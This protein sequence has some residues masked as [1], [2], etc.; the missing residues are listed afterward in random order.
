MVNFG[1]PPQPPAA[2]SAPPTLDA[3]QQLNL[4]IGRIPELPGDHASAVPH[5]ILVGTALPK[6]NVPA[7][8]VDRLTTHTAESWTQRVVAL[9]VRRRWR[10]ERQRQ[11]APTV[12]QPPSP[13]IG[14]LAASC[15]CSRQAIG[16]NWMSAQ[17]D[18]I[19]SRGVGGMKGRARARDSTA[20]GNTRGNALVRR[21][22][23]RRFLSA[24]S[25]CQPDMYGPPPVK[26]L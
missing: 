13:S 11:A 19:A 18:S 1:I 16:P 12:P 2:L 10:A 4:A 5:R 21:R 14:H 7:P 20:R 9:A 3:P 26:A 6:V 23:D 8:A 22:T 24:L 15:E 25:S 17:Y